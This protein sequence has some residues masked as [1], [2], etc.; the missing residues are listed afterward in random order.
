MVLRLLL[1]RMRVHLEGESFDILSAVPGC[2]A[3]FSRGPCAKVPA[4][5]SVVAG[6]EGGLRHKQHLRIQ[7]AHDE[8]DDA[9]AVHFVT[10]REYKK[11]YAHRDRPVLP[12][13]VGRPIPQPRDLELRLC[14]GPRSPQVALGDVAPLQAHECEHLLLLP[15]DPVVRGVQHDAPRLVEQRPH[16][17][18]RGPSEIQD[19]CELQGVV[20]RL[21]RPAMLQAATASDTG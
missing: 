20:N 3:V 4:P 16:H 9:S 8:P 6:G 17:R 15:V 5:A 13:D 19:A 7:V 18:K 21:H 10:L 12:R 14:G 2:V 1:A 11:N